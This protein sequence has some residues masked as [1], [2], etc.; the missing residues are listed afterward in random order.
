MSMNYGESRPTAS[1]GAPATNG[2]GCFL[3]LVFFVVGAAIS[4]LLYGS[5][6]ANPSFNNILPVLL[7][8]IVATLLGWL[9][10]LDADCAAVGTRHRTT[11]GTLQPHRRAGHLS[12][13]PLD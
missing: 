6:P 1:G 4:A 13:D 7:P 9:L 2:V 11:L 12:H 3:F 8:V 5:V 10:Y